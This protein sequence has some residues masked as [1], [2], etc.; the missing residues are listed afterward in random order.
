MTKINSHF[1][2]ACVASSRETLFTHLPAWLLLTKVKA[3]SLSCTKE[4]KAILQ[5][6]ESQRRRPLA[7]LAL[8]RAVC[9]PKVLVAVSSVLFHFT[10]LI[11]TKL[12]LSY[13]YRWWMRMYQMVFAVCYQANVNKCC[14]FHC[15]SNAWLP[16]N[17]LSFFSTFN[18]KSS[19]RRLRERKISAV[20]KVLLGNILCKKER[21]GKIAFE[22]DPETHKRRRRKFGANLPKSNIWRNSERVRQWSW[23]MIW[24]NCTWAHAPADLVFFSLPIYQPDFSVTSTE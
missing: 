20:E 2:F 7:P 23:W 3:T 17:H 13:S 18:D 24:A 6:E 10:P 16:R 14:Y 11:W 15:A 22:S 8:Q 21:E 5:R 12:Q 19:R 9:A 1:S 4:S